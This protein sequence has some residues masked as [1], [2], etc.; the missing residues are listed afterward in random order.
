MDQRCV[1][2]SSLSTPVSKQI[3]KQSDLPSDFLS[4]PLGAL[5][6]QQHHHRPRPLPSPSLSCELSS[7]VPQAQPPVRESGYILTLTFDNRTR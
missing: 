5:P 3:F 7:L 6:R 1:L 2:L 4:M